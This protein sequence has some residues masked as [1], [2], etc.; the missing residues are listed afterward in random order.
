MQ[1]RRRMQVDSAEMVEVKISKMLSG[2]TQWP[3]SEDTKRGL[4]EDYQLHLPSIVSPRRFVDCILAR[5]GIVKVNGN[6][7]CTL[8][9]GESITIENGIEYSN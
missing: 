2:F 6:L 7:T 9:E 4:M 5:F 1:F 8:E 3:L